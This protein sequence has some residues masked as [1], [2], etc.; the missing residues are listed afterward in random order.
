MLMVAPP[1]KVLGPIRSSGGWTFARLDG[2]T[3]AADTLLNDQL[4]GQ[5]TNEVLQ[6]RQQAFFASYMN[7]LRASSRVSDLRGGARGY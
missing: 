6:A 7:Q 5:L 3:P 4:K 1:G 2:I